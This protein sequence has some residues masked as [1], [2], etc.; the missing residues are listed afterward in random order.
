VTSTVRQTCK[1]GTLIRALERATGS[2]ERVLTPEEEGRLAFSGAVSQSGSLP[3]TVAVCDVGGGS[4]EIVAGTRSAGPALCHS[5]D[6]GSLRLTR[7]LLNG[8]PPRK[9]A[10]AAA[11][12]EV[13]AHFEDLEVPPVETAL[14]TGGSARSLRKLAGRKLGEQELARAVKTIAREPASRLA[15][16]LALDPLRAGTLLAGAIILAETQRRLGVPLEVA[17]G[18]LREG[19]AAALLEQ[20]VAA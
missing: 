3:E 16:D 7:R 10:V 1:T 6:V 2:P 15:R 11:T 14:A 20:L 5:L 18:G 19:A 13:A 17:R 4:T 9:K 8:D 12:R